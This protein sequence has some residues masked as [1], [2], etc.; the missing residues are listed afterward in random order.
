[1]ANYAE[2]DKSD[3]PTAIGVVFSAGAL[4]ALPAAPSDG[5]GG[6]RFC[7]GGGELL[8][9]CSPGP[10]DIPKV[11]VEVLKQNGVTVAV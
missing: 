3:T 2:F 5:H 1:V 7:A 9:R 8:D 6:F 10:T 11:V 4:D